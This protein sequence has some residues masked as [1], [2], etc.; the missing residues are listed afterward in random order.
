MSSSTSPRTPKTPTPVFRLVAARDRDDSVALA[1]EYVKARKS[2]GGPVKVLWGFTKVVFRERPLIAYPIAFTL[3]FLVYQG[4]V[5]WWTVP[6][7]FVGAIAAA[8]LFLVARGHKLVRRDLAPAVN[9]KTLPTYQEEALI[10]KATA[11]CKHYLPVIPQPVEGY[12]GQATVL[13]FVNSVP[14][15]TFLPRLPPQARPIDMGEMKVICDHLAT[16]DPELRITKVE[17]LSN[18]TFDEFHGHM[19]QLNE[20]NVRYLC[21]FLR[22]PLFFNDP[23][24][25]SVF[26]LKR[27]F[28]G[29][30]SP[31]GA[32]LADEQL[33]CVL[34]MNASYGNYLVPVAR[35]YDAVNTFDLS[36][37]LPRGLIRIELQDQ[38][39]P[40]AQCA[41]V[42]G[43]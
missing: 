35:L 10:A 36:K 11:L 15:H 19:R 30:W 28:G 16:F 8:I 22:A 1:L 37:G 4:Y 31:L 34:D 33:V 18:M 41:Q 20:P 12:C 7:L 42:Q 24:G 2:R 17:A 38:D 21:N 43:A 29:H 27:I 26:I 5:R 3:A 9:V 14:S 32:Y 6:L 40:K 13:N 39:T 25:S 23:K